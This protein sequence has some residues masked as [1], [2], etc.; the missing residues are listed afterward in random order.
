MA[1]KRKNEQERAAASLG[2]G[3]LFKGLGD[4]V[5]LVTG[6]IETDQEEIQRSGEFHVKGMGDKGRGVY[7]FTVRTG[8]GG[9]PRVDHFGNIRTTEGRG[10]GL[11]PDKNTAEG[12]ADAAGTYV[13]PDFDDKN[14][15]TWG[16]TPRN[17][18]CP[19][20]SKLKYKHCHGK[21]R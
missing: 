14:P 5:D 6:M 8:I 17:A 16:D 9:I 21:K 7:G 3:G 10:E 18:P 11:M 4:L 15:D 2:L 20:G 1:E 13:K 12:G 19:C